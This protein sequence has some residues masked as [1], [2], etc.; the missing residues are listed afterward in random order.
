[1]R[2]SVRL[3]KSEKRKKK[4]EEGESLSRRMT[5]GLPHTVLPARTADCQPQAKGTKSVL[6]EKPSHIREP[7]GR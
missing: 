2:M 7:R 3:L 1:M 5:Q 6:Q 4:E